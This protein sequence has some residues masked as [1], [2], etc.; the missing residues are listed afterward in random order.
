MYS[1]IYQNGG[2][3]IAIVHRCYD[4]LARKYKSQ[5]KRIGNKYGQYDRASINIQTHQLFYYAGK[6]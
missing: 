6:S 4:C 2:S 3:K 5:Y 1:C